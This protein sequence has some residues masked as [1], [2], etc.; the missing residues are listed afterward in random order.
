M[1]RGQQIGMEV[2]QTQAFETNVWNWTHNHVYMKHTNDKNLNKSN[3]TWDI[4]E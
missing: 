2:L 1:S 4:A 3:Y